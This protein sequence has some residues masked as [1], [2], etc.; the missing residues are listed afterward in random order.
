MAGD[1]NFKDRSTT[2][3]DPSTCDAPW[4]IAELAALYVLAR[5]GPLH[6]TDVCSTHEKN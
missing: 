3:V 6:L 5:H 2:F 1:R 4:G